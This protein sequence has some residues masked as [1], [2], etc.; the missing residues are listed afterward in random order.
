MLLLTDLRECKQIL[1]VP[2][3]N[4]SRDLLLS[5]YI[6]WASNWIQELL[7]RDLEKKSRTQYY[8]GSGS[9]RLILKSRP[10]FTSPTIQCWVDEA[11]YW[12]QPSDAFDDDPL[13]YGTD[14]V[15]IIDQD[16][17]TSRCAILESRKGY[18]P[19]PQARQQGLLSPF[20]GKGNGNIKV[21]YTAG[22]TT[23]TTPETLRQACV[24]LVA[25]MDY[26]F[27]LGM[28]IGS[29]SYEER[30]ISLVA[31]KDDYILRQ[32]KPLILAWR[33]WSW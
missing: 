2:T 9:R 8:S 33:N 13:T 17:G 11:G 3:G 29:E 24:L 15:L 16:D 21:T 14:Y 26:L 28:E 10:V 22:W 6:Q 1:Q 20:A 18:W 25:R 30:N 4:T 7:G 19:R 32:I 5:F 23:D 27:P 31:E 12:G